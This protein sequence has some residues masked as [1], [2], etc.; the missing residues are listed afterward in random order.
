MNKS[1][2]TFF[3]DVLGNDNFYYHPEDCWAYG[4][5]NSKLHVLP[6]GVLLPENSSQVQK[7]VKFCYENKITISPRGRGTGNTGGSIPKKK[8][9]VLSL[10]RMNKVLSINTIDRYCKVE[11]GI[12]NK[13]LQIELSKNNFFWAP[14]PSSM[15][16]ST[17]GGN[18]ANNSAG[19]RAIKYGTPRDNILGLKF[20]DGLGVSHSVGVHTSKGVVG[21]DLTRILVGSEG[22]L[23][24]ITEATLK[25]LPKKESLMTFEICFKKTSHSIDFI[26]FVMEKNH[27]PYSLEYLDKL[28]IKLI[29]NMMQGYFSNETES[30]LICEFDCNNEEKE[31]IKSFIRELSEKCFAVKMKFAKDKEN[32][33]KIWKARK[34]LS[35]AL[36][37]FGGYKIN[38]DVVVPI[39]NLNKFLKKVVE[40]GNH[41]NIQIVNFGHAG[42][43][44]IHVNL[45]LDSEQEKNSENT[46]SCLLKIFNLVIE[47]NGTL[48]GEHGI[49]IIKKEY[50]N[51]EVDAITT[52]LMKKIKSQFDPGGILNPDKSF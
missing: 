16:Y 13:D 35:P 42:N 14:D 7:V 45:I 40:I 18:I 22:T 47:L 41:H 21:L 28:S 44:N 2:I 5:D 46:K 25:I 31:N 26:K 10:E 33:Q 43:G 12:L 8:G 11:P 15:A 38:E 29:N 36:R 4:Y 24:V 32:I 49:G 39:T 6:D 52:D 20:I 50:L 17:I 1:Q 23:G 51:I 30:A 27:T 48:S 3:S 37:N 19:P 34:S 9:V